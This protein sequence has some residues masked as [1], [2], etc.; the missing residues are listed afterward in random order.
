MA[1]LP[2]APDRPTARPALRV[3]DARRRYGEVQALDGVSFQVAPGEVVAL[4]GPNG[5]GKSTLLR[6]ITTLERLD[7]GRIEVDGVDV[8]KDPAGARQRLGYAGQ[9]EALDKLMTGREFLRFQAGLVHLPR[10]VIRARVQELLERLDLAEAADRPCE[11]YSGGMR[12]R[13][14][15]AASLMHRPRLLIL[16]EPSTGLDLEARRRLWELLRG[17]RAEGTALLL[18]THDFEEADVL[19]DRVVLLARGQVVATGTPAELRRD[20]GHQVLG[21]A[22]HEHLRPGDRERLHELVRELPG[23]PLP[24]DPGSAELD[25]VLRGPEGNGHTPERWVETVEEAARARGLDLFQVLLRH[26][27]LQDVYRDAVARARGEEEEV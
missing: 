10:G 20:L 25:F 19:A 9:E 12:R 4:L 7:A 16:D 24:G 15:L 26:P 1:A 6:A 3:E 5:S 11:G 8:G 17:L 18:A 27:T 22:L 21:I 2:V 13:L 14:D 23:R